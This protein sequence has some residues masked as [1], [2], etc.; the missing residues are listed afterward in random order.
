MVKESVEKR[1]HSLKLVGRRVSSSG[2]N[3]EENEGERSV[4][5]AD[6]LTSRGE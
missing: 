2:E 3:E 5:N 6:L 1:G 4:R